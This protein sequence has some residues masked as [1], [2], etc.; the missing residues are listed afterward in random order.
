MTEH[1][2]EG[3]VPPHESA[4]GEGYVTGTAHFDLAGHRLK[5]R[6]DVPTGPVK[7]SRFL[8]LF[9][10]LTDAVVSV[11]VDRIEAAG[12]AI[13]CAKGCGA[14]CRQLVPISAME[15]RQIRDVV[16]D[17]PEPRRTRVRER[18]VETR[19]RLEEA[20]LLDRLLDPS[21]IDKQSGRQFGLEYFGHGIPCPFLEEESCSIHADRP[22]VCREYLVT[23]APE[24]CAEPKSETLRCVRLPAEVSTV[25][26]M[27][28]EPKGAYMSKWVPLSMAL[29]WAESHPDETPERPGTEVVN[30]FFTR[31][32]GKPPKDASLPTVAGEP[33]ASQA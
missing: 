33:E 7:P 14:C 23:S 27:W 5:L 21:K 8:P 3:H 22:L 32:A 15:A 4:G 25:L 16:D 10:S 12:Y 26:V 9:Q 13:S 19:K 1:D 20:G 2:T 6:L 28:D 24:H 30:D 11:A 29:E 18:F 31:F 17:M